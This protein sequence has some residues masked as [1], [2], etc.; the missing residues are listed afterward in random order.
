MPVERVSKAFKD[1][2]L[3]LQV[4]PITYDLIDIKNETAIARSIRNLVLTSPGERFFNQ[5]LGS[6]V[7]RSLFESLNDISS[8]V[9]QDEIRNTIENYEPRVDLISVD[10]VPNYDDNEFNVTI[11]YYIVGID[12]LPQELTF[13]LQSV[14]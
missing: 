4:N 8:T 10:V 11:R 2:S 13:A 7:S 3:S 1:I 5:N 14:R 9:I 12:S 6:N